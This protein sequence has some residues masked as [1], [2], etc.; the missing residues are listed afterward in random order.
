ME[1]RLKHHVITIDPGFAA[2][3]ARTDLQANSRLA[4]C[5][6]ADSGVLGPR[7]R[8]P[9]AGLLCGVRDVDHE[10]FPSRPEI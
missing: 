7:S 2:R 6:A 10:A 4:K 8:V 3:I 9:Q 1:V 5:R